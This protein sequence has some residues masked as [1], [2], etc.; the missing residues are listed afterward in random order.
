MSYLQRRLGTIDKTINNV[1]DLVDSITW[2]LSMGNGDKVEG[3][4]RREFTNRN[5]GRKMSSLIRNG[6]QGFHREVILAMSI[7]LLPD[8]YNHFVLGL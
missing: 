8:F 4:I 1:V 3:S 6:V 5:L 2:L 7:K